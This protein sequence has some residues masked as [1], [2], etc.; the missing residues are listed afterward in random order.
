[1]SYFFTSES[2]SEG[3]PD[4]V[5]DAISDSLLDLYLSHDSHARTAVEVLAT[6]NKVILSGET[7]SA[8]Q[9]KTEE[10]IR[11][12]KETIAKIG[13]TQPDFSPETVDIE[14]YLHSQ[15]PDIALGV[16]R[17]GAGD[18]GIMFG[19][20]RREEGFDTDYMPL[21]IYLAHKALY[22]LSNN[23]HNRTISGIEP[24]SKSQFTIEYDNL[25]KPQRISKIV[26]STQHDSELT[27]EEVRQ[28]VLKQLQKSVPENL[29]PD[30]KN[31]LI[32]PTGRF[33]IGGPAGDTGL[34]GRKIIV[35]TYGGAAP[36]GGG[37]F[38]GKD[39][40]K[41]DR[42]AAYM[43]RYLAKNIVAAGLAKECLLQISYAIGVAEPLSL[44]IDTKGSAKADEQ[45]ILNTVRNLV[46]LTPE[47]IIR[48]LDLRRPIYGPTSAYGHFGRNPDNCG[49]FSWEKLDL[50]KD[51]KNAFNIR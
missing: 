34:T 11:T 17:M 10:I 5:C 20:A 35:D 26:L 21:P 40:T 48:H 39:P 49:H 27:S 7:S 46:N 24:D 45:Q 16:D 6:T 15:S 36:H 43:M 25:G 4:K 33:V 14:N 13:Y 29:M 47:G 38:S 1:M 12:V 22:D 9:P 31:I 44:Y 50:V 32:N 23:R 2:V 8:W 37:A 41:V 19:Y 18:Q 3:H 42:S 28:I 30:N 51:L